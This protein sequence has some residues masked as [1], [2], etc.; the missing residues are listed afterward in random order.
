[1]AEELL[2]ALPFKLTAA[3]QKC[4][5]TIQDDLARPY[6]MLR[7]VQGVVGSGKTLVAVMA[8]LAAIKLDCK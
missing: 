2:S 5:Q 8:A 4:I 3:Q 7:L 1:M 6:P